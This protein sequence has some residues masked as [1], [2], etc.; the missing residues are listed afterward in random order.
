MKIIKG[1]LVRL[2]LQGQFD[3]I[4][5]GCNCFCTMGAG[6]ARQIKETCPKAFE[7]DAATRP[8]DESKL[9]NYTC[10]RIQTG[11]HRLTVVNG[12]TQFNYAGPGVLADYDAIEAL[13]TKIRTD[14]EGQRIGYPKIGA[15][16]AGGNWDRISRIIDRA[17]DGED[18]T[19]VIFDRS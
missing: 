15:G 1:D 9:G 14:F 16:L 2:G 17:L 4:I 8:G 13:F 3:L 7:A 19:L 5:H 6:I 18:H 12:Y 10:A 11:E